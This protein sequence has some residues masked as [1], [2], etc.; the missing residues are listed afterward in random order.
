MSHKMYSSKVIKYLLVSPN[1]IPM[2]SLWE[3][4]TQ[5]EI[6]IQQSQHIFLLNL[7]P[8]IRKLCIH[9]GRRDFFLKVG[10]RVVGCLFS[11]FSLIRSSQENSIFVEASYFLLSSGVSAQTVNVIGLVM[12]VGRVTWHNLAKGHMDI[13]GE[14]SQERLS[15]LLLEWL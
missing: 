1:N 13:T 5:G 7:I 15:L 4:Q 9:L 6:Y 14:S 12:F 2:K 11:I 3:T 10:V 8:A